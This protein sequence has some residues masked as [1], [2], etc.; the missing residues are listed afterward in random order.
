MSAP[1]NVVERLREQLAEYDRVRAVYGVAGLTPAFA[2]VDLVRE[3]LAEVEQRERIAV[4][5]SPPITREQLAA[6]APELLRDDLT[7]GTET[8]WDP[9]RPVYNAEGFLVGHHR[10][11]AIA[12]ELLRDD[13]TPGM[14]TP[15]WCNFPGCPEPDEHRIETGR[16]LVVRASEGEQ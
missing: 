7:P 11:A 9:Q 2:I 15:P 3:L 6:V 8:P 12:P 10:R 14:E 16:C 13:P 5:L 1:L 4:E